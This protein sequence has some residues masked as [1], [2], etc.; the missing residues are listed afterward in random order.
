MGVSSSSGCNLFSF[1]FFHKQ[2]SLRAICALWIE[3]RLHTLHTALFSFP[4]G[5][6][7]VGW[8]EESNCGRSNPLS[9]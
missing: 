6:A 1:G 9:R 8:W 7:A 5:S 4:S 2:E 3:Y